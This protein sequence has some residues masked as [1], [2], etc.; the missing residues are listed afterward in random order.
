MNLFDAVIANNVKVVRE[1]LEKGVDPNS[2]EDADGVTLLHFAA[3]HNA[4]DSAKLLLAAG[5]KVDAET[6]E[7]ITPLDVAKLHKH[8]NMIELLL[9]VK[10]SQ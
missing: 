1:L 7:G 4:I 10:S 3:Q 6:V 2:V 5:A 8:H 9:R